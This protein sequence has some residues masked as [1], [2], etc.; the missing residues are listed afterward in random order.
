MSFTGSQSATNAPRLLWVVDMNNPASPQIIHTHS[1]DENENGRANDIAVCP[2]TVAVTLESPT[3][4]KE[5]HVEFFTPFKRGDSSIVRLGRETGECI[6]ILQDKYEM[7]F[8]RYQECL[9]YYRLM[10]P[11]YPLVSSNFS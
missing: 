10:A 8:D 4:T 5:G 1:F 9:I 11:G 7:D 2:D 6:Y 3:P